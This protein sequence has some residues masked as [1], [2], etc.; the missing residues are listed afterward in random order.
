MKNNRSWSDRCPDPP[1]PEISEGSPEPDSG[2]YQ[3]RIFVSEDI[4]LSVGSLGE[5]TLERGEYVYTGSAMKNLAKRVAR[6]LRKEKKIRWH[7]DYLLANPAAGISGVEIF[8][9][10]TRDECAF[11]Q[12]L[13]EK[14]AEIPVTGFGSSDCRCCP[15]HLVRIG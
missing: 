3:L 10:E 12:T 1:S 15:S 6:H 4:A 11:N 14:G 2:C 5:V 7:I 8:P 13:I 9:S